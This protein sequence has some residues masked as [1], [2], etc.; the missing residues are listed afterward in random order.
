MTNISLM[1]NYW[2][3]IGISSQNCRFEGVFDYQYHKIIN[4]LVE[5]ETIET[6]EDNVFGVC[7]N[8]KFINKEQVNYLLIIGI[9]STCILA[10][11]IVI[12]IIIKK[13]MDKK[14]KR[15]IVIP[16][17]EKKDDAPRF[18]ISNEIPRPNFDNFNKK[19]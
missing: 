13:K 5:D 11:L 17:K 15:V 14:P 4:S 2:I 16:P 18:N 10:F 12:A 7:F 8:A 6:I 9:V 19:K 3:P 1:G